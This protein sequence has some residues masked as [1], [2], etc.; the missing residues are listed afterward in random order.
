MV[1]KM[2]LNFSF[3][4][5]LLCMLTFNA[6]SQQINETHQV[7]IKCGTNL[8]T[9]TFAYKED[10][11]WKGYDADICR[12]FSW[13]LYGN[14]DMFDMVD[15][16][17]YEIE[18]AL[19]SGKID[20]MLSNNAS[21]ASMEAKNKA[22][23]VALLYYDRQMFATKDA[24][25]NISSMNDFKGKKVCV[26][27][28]SDY[29]DNLREY[30]KKYKLDFHIM[31]FKSLR[32]ARNAFLLKRCDLITYQGLQLQ[33]IISDSPGKNLQIL[34]EE[35][36]FFPVYAYVSPY[37]N[38]LRIV[39]KWVFNSLYAAEDMGLNK[40]NAAEFYYKNNQ[41]NQNLFGDDD[42]LWKY[43]KVQPS[44]L[45]SAIADVG[46]MGE[47]FERNLGSQSEFK[48]KRGKASL[49]KDGGT[50]TVMP[51]M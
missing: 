34:P 8:N 18:K 51:F 12:A 39:A 27:A 14:G 15:V 49:L 2:K 4:I 43:L 31:V 1:R 33:Q 5:L 50:V 16:K 6:N 22:S 28:G 7:G 48:L 23:S 38:A 20:I 40:E 36:A 13:A 42:M 21:M 17:T 10:G 44:W 25:E 26:F 35:F 9:D 47:I 45:R 24:P 46:N 19:T 32:K 30:N 37:N 11:V 41:M 3:A 29:L